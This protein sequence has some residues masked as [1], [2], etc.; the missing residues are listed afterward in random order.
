MIEAM[1]SSN[2][3]QQFIRNYR[4]C[5]HLDRYFTVMKKQMRHHYFSKRGR[6]N[7][8]TSETKMENNI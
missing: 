3:L 8:L 2:L 4:Y 1:P 5:V 7:E 6:G